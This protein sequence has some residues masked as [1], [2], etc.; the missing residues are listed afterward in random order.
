MGNGSWNHWKNIGFL[1]AGICVGALVMWGVGSLRDGGSPSADAPKGQESLSGSGMENDED[2]PETDGAVIEAAVK[3]LQEVDYPFY[4]GREEW[5]LVL[6]KVAV[7]SGAE[8]AEGGYFFRMYDERGE[9]RQKFPFDMEAEELIFRFDRLS[10]NRDLAVFPQGAEENGETGLLFIWDIEKNGFLEDPITIPW[11]EVF[12]PY[13][14]VYLVRNREDNVEFQSI[15][16][17]NVKTMQPVE[18]RRW[19]LTNPDD[20]ALG[21]LEIWNCLKQTA[22]YDGEVEFNELGELA[23]NKFYQG[24]FLREL[25]GFWDHEQE[26][27]GLTVVEVTWDG[28]WEDYEYRTYDSREQFL[29]DMGFAEAEPFYEYVDMNRELMLELYFNGETGQGCGL[30][31][32]YSYNYGLE[33]ITD[34][35]G[36]IFH[37]MTAGEWTPDEPYSTLSVYGDDPRDRGTYH[38]REI[39]E[40]TEDGKLSGFEARG[41]IPYVWEDNEETTLLSMSYYYRDDGTLSYK[42]YHHDSPTSASS[43]RS[44]YDEL[45]RP[46][47]VSCY[48]TH[49]S[50]EYFY[51]YEDDG[52][53]PAYIFKLDVYPDSVWPEMIKYE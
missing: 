20:D 48:I 35:Y 42:A 21:H 3:E 26:P 47:Y 43:L 23:N 46:V 5:R 9:L 19:T 18:L 6:C 11:Y 24:I 50:L 1:L 32:D 16:R 12:E 51:I 30:Y 27:S 29:A 4:Y 41:I 40:Y 45:E 36:F 25:E 38:Y 14:Q 44:W 17:I 28:E 22:L 2:T 13:G 10:G 15:Y 37:R 39:Y 49:G 53:R 33:E 7:E 8:T 34:S 31:Y 52:D